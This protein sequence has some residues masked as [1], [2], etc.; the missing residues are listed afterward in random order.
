MQ[1]LNVL[2]ALLLSGADA[3]STAKTLQDVLTQLKATEGAVHKL[4]QDSA[5]LEANTTKLEAVTAGSMMNETNVSTD[6][7]RLEFMTKWNNKTL[8]HFSYW[9]SQ[10]KEKLDFERYDLG[11][12]DTTKKD[13]QAA[14]VTLAAKANQTVT[15]ANLTKLEEISTKIWRV[16]DPQSKASLDKTEAK[17]KSMDDEIVRLRKELDPVIKQKMKTKMRRQVDGWRK[18]NFQ[19]G[20]IALRNAGELEKYFLDPRDDSGTETEMPVD[21]DSPEWAKGDEWFLQ[22][23]SSRLGKN[24]DSTSRSF[25]PRE[26]SSEAYLPLPMDSFTSA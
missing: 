26:G 1:H 15:K 24:K 8:N 22:V 16:S 18:E 14:A 21:E 13:T 12:S 10:L 23:D 9:F 19:L 11:T 17:L 7:L 20:K 2:F 25:L 3:Q 4:W 5:T 6:L